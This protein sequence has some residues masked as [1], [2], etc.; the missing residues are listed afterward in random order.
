MQPNPEKPD[1]FARLFWT[2]MTGQ[3]FHVNIVGLS[4][5]T[6]SFDYEFGSGFFDI[7]GRALLENGQFKAQVMLTKSETMIEANF[8]IEGTAH[9]ICDR[10][11]EPFDYPMNIDRRIVF[12]FGQEEK[13]LSDE[14]LVITR[15]HER[16]DVGQYMYELIGVSLPMKRLHPKFQNEDLEESEIQLVYTSPV[17]KTGDDDAIDPRWEKLKKLK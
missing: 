14:I 13:E 4:N 10:S 3:D 6:H 12:K 16:L 9:L 8:H 17:E 15:E 7:Y 2:Q 11:L 5:K 1:K